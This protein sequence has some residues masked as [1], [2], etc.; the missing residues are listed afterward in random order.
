MLS[1]FGSVV[2]FIF[3]PSRTIAL[4]DFVEPSEARAAFKGLAYRKYKHLPLYL[5]WAPLGVLDKSKRPSAPGSVPGGSNVA[6]ATS[7]AGAEESGAG[8]GNRA[9][10]TGG[11]AANDEY[12]TLY[13]KNLNFETTEDGLQ[14]HLR[15]HGCADVRAV[16]LPTK[17]VGSHSLPMGF[18]FV[19]FRSAAA[20]VAALPRLHGSLLDG[21]A[22]EAKASTKRL[23]GTAGASSGGSGTVAAKRALSEAFAN[24]V[25]P[26]AK[27]IVRNVAFQA[28]PAELR[29]LFAAFGSIKR[30]RIPKKMGGVH[31]GFAFVEFSSAQ[32]AANAMASLTGVSSHTVLC[33]TVFCS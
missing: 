20:A 9:T 4:V 22:L 5:E 18:G 8:G 11:D 2:S 3:P 28:T 25:K 26:S 15:K 33:T 30:V 13:L 16:S 31:R 23:S 14:R 27:L 12:S 19:E 10:S 32:E 21:H 24:G 7:K 1:R 17:V 6:A 29:N